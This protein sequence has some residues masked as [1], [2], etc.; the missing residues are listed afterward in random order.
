MLLGIF[1]FPLFTLMRHSSFFHFL[2]LLAFLFQLTACENIV[3]DEPVSGEA[4]NRSTLHI[5]TRAIDGVSL[6]YP[7]FCYAFA[8]DGSLQSQVVIE[9]ADNAPSLSLPKGKPYRIVVLSADAQRYALPQRPT[10]SSVIS[11]ASS[12]GFVDAHPLM[13]GFADVAASQ[14]SSV[15]CS[16]QLQHQMSSLSLSLRQVPAS[17]TDVTVSVS[18]PYSGITMSGVGQMAPTTV[19]I[20]LTRSLDASGTYT[21]ESGQIYLFPTCAPQTVFTIGYTD[22]EGEQYSSVTYQSV[23]SAGTPYQLNGTFT[24]GMLQLQADILPSQWGTPVCLDFEFGDGKNSVIS[25]Q[26]EVHTGSGDEPGSGVVTPTDD[27]EFTVS[28]IPSP[29]TLW[30]GHVVA[31]VLDADGQPVAEP[32]Q[33]ARLLL[34]SLQDWGNMTSAFNET[35]PSQA[36]SLAQS[37]AEDALTGWRIPSEDE[38]RLLYS[39]YNDSSSGSSPLEKLLGSSSASP[40]ALVDDKGEKLRYLCADAKKTYSFGV[41]SVLAAGKTIKTYHLR[42]VKTVKVIVSQ[43]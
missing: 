17:C 22:E 36:F 38:G 10:L 25:A 20:P 12:Q 31:A 14:S 26:G 43:P 3:L 35:N 4:D 13:M 37:Y 18:S 40:V 24:N 21:W 33:E 2:L 15:T 34:M 32:V 1:H 19:S 42:L 30:Q 6:Q 23:L 39:A 9:S 8:S 29:Y 11:V 16:I 7:L 27:E 28:S 5:Y 41:N